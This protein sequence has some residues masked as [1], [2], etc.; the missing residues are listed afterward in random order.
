MRVE[1]IRTPKHL[2]LVDGNNNYNKSCFATTVC[3]RWRITSITPWI[4]FEVENCSIL[5][6]SGSIWL[7]LSF[8]RIYSSL[9]KMNLNYCAYSVLNRINSFYSIYP[10]YHNRSLLF[11][12]HVLLVIK[13]VHHTKKQSLLLIIFIQLHPQGVF[14]WYIIYML[15]SYAVFTKIDYFPSHIH[16][17]LAASQIINH[18]T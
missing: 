14:I 8:E 6:W 15:L 17:Q 5:F 7:L 10:Y 3:V 2:Y 11:I 18:I 16:R 13:G 12:Y 9:L 4:N 1:R